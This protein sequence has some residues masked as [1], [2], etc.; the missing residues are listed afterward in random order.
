[1]QVEE[2]STAGRGGVQLVTDKHAGT[3]WLLV[4]HATWRD[5][6][7]YSCV[8]AHGRPTTVSIHVLDGEWCPFSCSLGAPVPC[9]Y[10]LLLLGYLVLFQLLV[11]FSCSLLL[12]IARTYVLLLPSSSGL[13]HLSSLVSSLPYFFPISC[14]CS[15]L[16]LPSS[17][18]LLHL[19]SPVPLV[20]QFPH[21]CSVHFLPRFFFQSSVIVFFLFLVFCTYVLQFP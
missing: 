3:S 11:L 14:S 4:T 21:L 18:S 10:V 2:I 9:A 20:S 1:M 12:S 17:P 8:P 5:A 13:L 16:S 6:G 19:C 7:N 15:V